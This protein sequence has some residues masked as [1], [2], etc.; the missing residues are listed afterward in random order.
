MY[1]QMQ[2]NNKVE[3]CFWQ[4]DEQK[5]IMMR[6][7]GEIQ[8]VNDVELKKKVL[9]YKPFLKEFGMTFEHPGLIIF[10]IAKGEAYLWA[11]ATNL[12]PKEMIKF[13]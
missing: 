1:G 7:A 5:G 8:F 4:P 12:Q 11:I 2:A 13:G 9:E 6:V 3:P 10:R